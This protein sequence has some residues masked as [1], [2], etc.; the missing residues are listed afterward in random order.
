MEL[1]LILMVALFTYTAA[2]RLQLS[3]IMALF[4]CDTRTQLNPT[5]LIS[6]H[7]RLHVQARNPEAISVLIEHRVALGMH[8]H[9]RCCLTKDFTC[10]RL[11]CGAATRHYTYHNLSR[12]AQDS[13]MSLFMTAA[14]LAETALSTL[15]GVALFD[16]MLWSLGALAW[17]GPP[18][19]VTFALCT[20]PILLLSRAFNIFPLSALSNWCALSASQ[21]PSSPLPSTSISPSHE[22]WLLPSPS[23][24]SSLELSPSQPSRSTSRLPSLSPQVPT[25]REA[26]QSTYAG[27]DVV[28]MHAGCALVCV[29]RH[30]QRPESTCLSQRLPSGPTTPALRQP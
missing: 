9:A 25:R 13:S 2:E 14:S 7:G 26:Y 20:F 6:T 30:S 15:L 29:G 4:T 8:N 22:P 24:L 21:S 28:L 10:S 1:A 18:F 5:G 19:D 27:R 23:P 12:E 3:G 17:D 16:Y 11:R